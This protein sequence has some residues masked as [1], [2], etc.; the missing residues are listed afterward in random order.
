MKNN[1]IINPD[2]KFF[3]SA[4]EW[5][6]NYCTFLGKFTNSGGEKFDLGILL[7]GDIKGQ[8]CAACV[9]GNTPGNY[10]SGARFMY[11]NKD[12]EMRDGLEEFEHI[13]EMVRRARLLNL[14]E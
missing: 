4:D 10:I 14:I 5:M 11:L 13:I 3:P 1:F 7:E 2:D 9:Y 6:W 12:G 8:W